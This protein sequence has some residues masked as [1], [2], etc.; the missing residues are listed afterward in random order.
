MKNYNH[1]TGCTIGQG[2]G[3]TTC[4][5]LNQLYPPQTQTWASHST[6][7]PSSMR[8]S[9]RPHGC[10]S[11]PKYGAPT[12]DQNQPPPS[13]T[14][15]PNRSVSLLFIRLFYL[16][17]RALLTCSS[18]CCF[19]TGVICIRHYLLLILMVS[20]IMMTYTRLDAAYRHLLK[21]ILTKENLK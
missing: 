10:L 14:P 17:L 18:E 6:K 4:M 13:Y 5:T 16:H 21:F 19:D 1:W 3:H 15:S 8:Q 12:T 20:D 2:T 7:S 11:S 9:S